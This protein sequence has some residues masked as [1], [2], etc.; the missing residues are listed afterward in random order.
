MGGNWNTRL[1]ET[2]KSL[3]FL[4]FKKGLRV[5]LEVVQ[6]IFDLVS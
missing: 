2:V 6:V 1:I 4:A 3:L 5:L